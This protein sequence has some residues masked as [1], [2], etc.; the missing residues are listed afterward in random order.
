MSDFDQH[1]YDIRCEWGLQGLSELLPTSDTVIIVDVLSFS[2]CVDIATS[3]GAVVY[4]YHAK[5]QSA[6]D[7]AE[8]LQALLATPARHTEPGSYSLSPHSLLTI[9]TGTRLVLPSPNGATLSRATGDVATFAACLR[10]ASAVARHVQALG[11]KISVIPAGE[12]WRDGSLRP[13]LEDLLGAGAIIHALSGSKSP[14]AILAERGF[15]HFR[16][17]LPEA[18]AQ[19]GSGR[20]LIAR[21]FGPDVALAASLNVSVSVPQLQQGAYVAG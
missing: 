6:V 3:N 4:P 13:S 10:N 11:S 20:E 2:T 8:S 15:L 1:G 17:T 14:E 9:P 18:L 5:D 16:S 19:C 7:Y 21:G 12:R